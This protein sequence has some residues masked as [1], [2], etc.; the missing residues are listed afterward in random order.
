MFW[1]KEHAITLIPA[2]IVMIL[3]TFVLRIFLKNKP[4]KIRMIPFQVITVILL[5]IEVGKQ[6]YS[7]SHGY[8]LYHIPLHFC[9]LFLYTLPFM[10][11]Y[12]GKYKQEV[13]TIAC[14]AMT[15]LFMFLLIY[16]NLIYGPGNIIN[17]FNGYLDFHTVFFHNLVLFAFF[18]SI[19]LDLHTPAK[20]K[21][22]FIAVLIFITAYAVIAGSM[23]QI[24]EVNFSN[25]FE[26][27]VPPVASL[28][29]SL[30]ASFGETLIQTVYVV[31]LAILHVIFIIGMYYLFRLIINIKLKITKSK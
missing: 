24:I 3:L 9:S 7:I 4:L 15:A 19:G 22:E 2:S 10:A 31:V 6:V 16:P 30:K 21:K 25:F 28:I 11:F 29:E 27:N 14:N 12:N 1:T 20:T 23:A 8:D 26:C 17:F 5:V 13:N 18:I